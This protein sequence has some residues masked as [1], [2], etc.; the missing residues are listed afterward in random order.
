V[1]KSARID[2]ICYCSDT[3]NDPVIGHPG[4][5]LENV[6]MLT[7]AAGK[8]EKPYYLLSTRSGV[9]NRLAS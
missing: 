4:R 9:M 3:S 2:A 1:N 6:A 5:V 8:R 7:A